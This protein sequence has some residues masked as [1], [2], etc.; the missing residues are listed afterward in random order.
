MKNIYASVLAVSLFSPVVI[1]TE[2]ADLSYEGALTGSIIGSSESKV[3]TDYLGVL[4]LDV[5]IPAFNGQWHIYIEGTTTSLDGRVN[6]VYVEANA[7]AGAAVGSDGKGRLQISN[8]EYRHSLGI[9][10]VSIGLLYPSGFSET[11]DWSNDETSQFI[12][13]MFANI[14]TIANPDYALGIGYTTEPSDAIPGISVLLSQAEGLADLDGSYHDLFSDSNDIFFTTELRWN[15]NLV[16]LRIGAWINDA[17]FERLDGD[18]DD[19][20]YGLNV[21]VAVQ[22]T[23]NGRLVFRYGMANDEVSEGDIFWGLSYQHSFDKLTIGLGHAQTLASDDLSDQGGDDIKQTE[24][25]LRQ[26]LWDGFYATLSYQ[27][28]SESSF[29]FTPGV[30]SSPNIYTLRLSQEF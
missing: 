2:T 11:G 19:N 5:F 20:N 16:D 22:N 25:Y 26:Q 1:A 17:D 21:S 9:G 6:A 8:L 23:E 29:G 14:Q 30:D 10:D 24:V 13:S 18:G 27:H 4:D 12:G 7:D 3:D 15:Y 28:I